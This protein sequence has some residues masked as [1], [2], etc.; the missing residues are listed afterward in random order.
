M[1]NIEGIAK[2]IRMQAA[3]TDRSRS[4]V[5]EYHTAQAAVERQDCHTAA[6]GVHM[7]DAALHNLLLAAAAVVEAMMTKMDL[8]TQTHWYSPLA[9]ANHIEALAV[10]HTDLQEAAVS[11]AAAAGTN[12]SRLPSPP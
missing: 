6:A 8:H 12:T 7:L 5:Q 4:Q 11:T 1:R 3:A 9:E 10:V 2:S